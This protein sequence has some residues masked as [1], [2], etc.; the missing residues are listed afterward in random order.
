[1]KN[2]KWHRDEIILALNLYFKIEPGQIHARNPE[3]IEL[4]EI[5]NRIPIHKERP[6]QTKFRNPNGVGL[7]LSNLLA[8]DPDY[9]GKGM[10]SFSKLDKDIFHEFQH[11]KPELTRI[12]N[13]IKAT[14]N[15]TSLGM[16]L[17]QIGNDEGEESL[18]VKE[19]KVIYK[20]HKHFERNNK[21]NKKKKDQYLSKK[22]KLDCEVCGFDFYECYGELGKGFI[23][24]HHR[25]PLHEIEG[26][27]ETK[28]NDLALVC[29]NCHRMLHRNLDTLSISE[30]K[31]RIT[32]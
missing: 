20:L 3:I 6:D 22:G 28:L 29:A 32:Q 27:S 11:N 10:G 16:K 17:Y 1:V 19:G 24:C 25:T 14:I 12:A 4:S 9:K 7:K 21:I 18:T 13:K 31:N 5:L 30:L 2:P 15:N 26:E 8:I 23:E